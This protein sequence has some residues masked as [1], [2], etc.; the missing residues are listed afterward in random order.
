MQLQYE[1]VMYIILFPMH[2]DM[3]WGFAIYESYVNGPRSRQGETDV[4]S[5]PFSEGSYITSRKT[6][7]TVQYWEQEA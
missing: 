4:T 5:H 2:E 1:Q 3:Q 7:L 6:N